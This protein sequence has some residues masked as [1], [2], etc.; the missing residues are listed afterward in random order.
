[1]STTWGPCRNAG[2]DSLGAACFPY[3]MQRLPAHGPHRG[4]QPDTH[5]GPCSSPPAEAQAAV[6][7]Q[8]RKLR[9]DFG[10]QGLPDAGK[11]K[12]RDEQPQL[13]AQPRAAGGCCSV[14]RLGP[15]R[16][17]GGT[18]LPKPTA[19]RLQLQNCSPGEPEMVMILNHVKKKTQGTKQRKA[20]RVE[21]GLEGMNQQCSQVLSLV[22]SL[23]V[24]LWVT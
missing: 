18:G 6:T 19:P 12:P 1:M 10:V 24:R 17:K 14:G 16:S 7:S 4:A 8:P 5:S 13:P 15:A 22:V 23:V 11:Y 20:L 9:T 2:S 21:K 3:V